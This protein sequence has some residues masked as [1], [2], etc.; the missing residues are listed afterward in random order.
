M[1]FLDH[2]LGMWLLLGLVAGAL[3]LPFNRAAAEKVFKHLFLTLTVFLFAPRLLASV[4]EGMSRLEIGITAIVI[5]FA[6]YAALE[7]RRHGH[8]REQS[9]HKRTERSPLVPRGKN[10]H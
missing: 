3:V 8:G 10:G 1:S 2:L 5:S 4:A 9:Q 6:A 7:K